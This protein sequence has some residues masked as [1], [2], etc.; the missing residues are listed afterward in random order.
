V[1]AQKRHQKAESDKDLNGVEFVKVKVNG[2]SLAV[3]RLAPSY[4]SNSEKPAE[5]NVELVLIPYS[6]W[7]NPV[8]GGMRV[9][10]P[11]VN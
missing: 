7:G 5:T 8:M 4:S 2:S 3:D 11:V 1:A 9:W 6:R 10:I